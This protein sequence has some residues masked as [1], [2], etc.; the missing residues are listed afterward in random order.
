MIERLVMVRWVVKSI[1][2]GGPNE[3]FL[4]PSSAATFWLAARDLLYMHNPT[5]RIVHTMP[6]VT[7]VVEHWL[8]KELAH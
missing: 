3:L 8:E 1:L 2:H 7:L 5:Y 6:F 4:I